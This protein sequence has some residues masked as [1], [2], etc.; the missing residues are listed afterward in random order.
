MKKFLILIVL[1]LSLTAC[2]P[3]KKVP[4]TW[5]A[6]KGA[7]SV[8]LIPIL[9]AD[10][11][12]V[13][14][15]DGTDI[16]S[17]ALIQGSKDIIIAP[18]NLGSKLIQAGNADYKLLA[19]VTWGNLYILKDAAVP[20]SENMNL[21]MFGQNA[22]PE[23]VLN[24]VSDQLD[25]TYTKV[26][27]N[28]VADVK[29]QLV[30]KVYSLGLLAEPVATATIVAAKAAGITIS[31]VADLQEAWKSKTGYDNY[32]QAAIFVKNGL[33][34]AQLKQIKERITLMIDYVS[35]VDADKTVV[36]TDITALTAELVGVPSA[37]IVKATWAN[38]NVDVKYASDVK[39][40]IKTFLALFNIVLDDAD[41]I[42]K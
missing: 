11:D 39:D 24:H 34:T 28:S 31:V 42:L 3:A 33:S 6:P 20:F 4:F 9:K 30:A 36:E 14:S 27:F 13:E 15:V 18:I 2:V 23:L 16:L 21:A 32:P 41:L 37:A 40:E 19:V 17:A 25:F 22:V 35:S 5:L 10:F 1:I 26:P 12:Q 8:A 38:L 29:G 7:P